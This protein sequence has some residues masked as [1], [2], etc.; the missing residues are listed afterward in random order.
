MH[1]H[2]VVRI[3]RPPSRRSRQRPA[4][5]AD[6]AEAEALE[7]NVDTRLGEAAQAGEWVELVFAVRGRVDRVAG[8]HRHRWRIRTR[9]GHVVSFR[10]EFVIGIT[11]PTRQLVDVSRAPAEEAARVTENGRE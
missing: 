8:R 3:E 5:G 7:L 9:R 11:A 6:A 2:V 1:R 4:D 10:P